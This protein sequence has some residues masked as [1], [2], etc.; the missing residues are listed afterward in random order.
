LTAPAHRRRGLTS[1]LLGLAASW[2]D[3]RGCRHWVIVADPDSDASRL[4]RARGF[5]DTERLTQAYR[6]DAA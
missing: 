6:S 2:A 1:H 5:T 3:N 4:Y